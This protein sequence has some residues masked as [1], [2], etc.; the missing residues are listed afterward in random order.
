MTN[1]EKIYR[2]WKLLDDID[3]L[4][5]ACRSDDAR[6]RSLAR[7]MQQKRFGIVSGE[8]FYLLQKEFGRE[9]DSMW[10]GLT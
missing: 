10:S 7:K 6:F 9:T 8:E 5:D 4:D 1:E 2:L 3:T